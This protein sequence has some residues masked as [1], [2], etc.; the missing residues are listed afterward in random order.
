MDKLPQKYEKEFLFR[1]FVA[2][3]I[4]DAP[5]VFFKDSDPR[6]LLHRVLKTAHRTIEC[7][8]KN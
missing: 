6:V 4:N 8:S 5:F 1:Q 2:N 7:H 3:I